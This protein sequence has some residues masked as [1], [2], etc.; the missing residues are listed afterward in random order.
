[1]E[2]TSENNRQKGQRAEDLAADHLAKKGYQILCR[3]WTAGKLE[4]DLIAAS[5]THLAFVEVKSRSSRA[6]GAPLEAV[7]S[8][9]RRSIVR[10]ADI[11]LSRSDNAL[12]PR[13]DIISIVMETPPEIEHIEGAFFP[14]A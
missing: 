10:A 7:N 12:E 13:F 9:K 6:F 5:K 11:Y 2:S 1:V 4:I 14:H 8:A 3:N